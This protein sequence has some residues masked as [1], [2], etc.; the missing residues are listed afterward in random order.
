MTDG[1]SVQ[2]LDEQMKMIEQARSGCALAREA[3]IVSC[4]P[5]VRTMA[6]YYAKTF[7]FEFDELV[8][9]GNLVLVEKLD[10]ALTKENAF[11]YLKGCVKRHLKLACFKGWY[12]KHDSLEDFD[13]AEESIKPNFSYLY[14]AIDRLP[15]HYREVILMRYGLLGTPKLSLFEESLNSSANPKGT[16]LYMRLRRAIVLL[17]SL[18]VQTSG[19]HNGMG[20]T[21]PISAKDSAA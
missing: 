20:E 5:Y 7:Q 18:L 14:R 13:I 10:F 1:T 8:S 11:S 12:A 9:I 15:P 21:Y 6:I 16:I 2:S 3:I 19:Q 4:M 17:R